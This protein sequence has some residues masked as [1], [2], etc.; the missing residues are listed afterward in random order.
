MESAPRSLKINYTIL[1]SVLS[2]THETTIDRTWKDQATGEWKQD[3]RDLG[4]FVLFDGS[5]EKM[6]FGSEKP[7]LEVGD[8]IKITIEKLNAEATPPS[9]DS[10]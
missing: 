9:T 7:H 1:T 4:W 8:K 10:R 6:H 5:H 3:I 2:I